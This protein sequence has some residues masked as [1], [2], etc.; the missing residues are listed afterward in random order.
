ML[1]KDQIYKKECCHQCSSKIINWFQNVEL[2]SIEFFC[3]LTLSILKCISY[4]SK[5][6]WLKMP[7]MYS[8]KKKSDEWQNDFVMLCSEV[9][10]LIKNEKIM[11]LNLSSTA[12]YEFTIRLNNTALSI[13]GSIFF[14]VKKSYSSDM[15]NYFIR[16]NFTLIVLCKLNDWSNLFLSKPIMNL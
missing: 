8:Y 9:T 13:K 15:E 10:R 14:C 7:I 3:E 1:I 4:S 5:K 12:F 16:Q 6:Y 11:M 2:I